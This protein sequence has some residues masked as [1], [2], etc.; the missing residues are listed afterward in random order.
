MNQQAVRCEERVQATAMSC[1][2]AATLFPLMSDADLEPLV[3]SMR[4][5]GFDAEH[6]VLRYRGEVLDGRN[7]LRAAELAGVQPV[8]RDLPDDC[9]PYIESWKH[10]GARRHLPPSQIAAIGVMVIE[11]S[12]TWK[13]ERE[14]RRMA[15]N[16]AR[17]EKAKGQISTQTRD[18][19]GRV[20]PGGASHEARPGQKTD[21]GKTAKLIADHAGISRSTVERM[22][23]LGKEDP[24]KLVAIARGEKSERKRPVPRI[25]REQR[26]ADVLRLHQQGMRTVEI[27]RELR[28]HPDLVSEAK[29]ALGI[30]ATSP[31]RKLWADIEHATTT[32]SGA[33]QRFEEL[34]L[35]LGSQSQLQTTAEEI[36]SCVRSLAKAIHQVRLLQNALKSAKPQAR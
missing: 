22:Q 8:Y 32:L 25:N 6:P 23:K 27:A 2:H 31:A 9:D 20:Q 12:D 1:H 4:E 15:A 7:R 30:A 34:S 35:C 24:A 5:G 14:E 13:R 29:V 11:Q 18:E 36:E 33:G 16:V 17:A 19:A 21:A 26:H 28:I 10:N 3:A